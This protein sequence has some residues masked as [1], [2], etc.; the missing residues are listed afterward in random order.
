[1]RITPLETV[2]GINYIFYHCAERKARE[3][4][5]GR[6]SSYDKMV[7]DVNGFYAKESIGAA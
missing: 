5:F 6:K 4:D 2:D 3:I 7:K 1:M